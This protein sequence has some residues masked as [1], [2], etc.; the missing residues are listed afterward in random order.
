MTLVHVLILAAFLGVGNYLNRLSVFSLLT[1]TVVTKHTVIT[2]LGNFLFWLNVAVTSLAM[3]FLPFHKKTSGFFYG[4][5]V[6]SELCIQVYVILA[7]LTLML[8]FKIKG[9]TLAWIYLVVIRVFLFVLVSG[10]AILLK[11]F[12]VDDSSQKVDTIGNNKWRPSF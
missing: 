10:I 6:A 1:K 8:V 9:Q 2:G 11:F 7:F 4:F 5:S 12:G 3:L